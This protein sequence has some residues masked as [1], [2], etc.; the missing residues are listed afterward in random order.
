MKKIVVLS[1]AGISA[2]SGIATFRDSNG[3][4]ENH[5]TE[6]VASPEAWQRDP[7]LVNAFYNERRKA[8]LAANPN[9]AHKL[10]AG[11]EKDYDVQ[12]ITQN[13]DDLH[14][15]G[16]S[17]KVLHLHGSILQM[18]CERDPS[19]TEPI[20]TD[21]TDAHRSPEGHA[22]R[23]AIVWFGEP[24]LAL[25]EAAFLIAK[26]DILVIIGTSMQVWP[27]SGLIN[28]SPEHA[29]IYLI[30]KHLPAVGYYPKLIPIEQPATVGV[31]QL[32]AILQPK[33]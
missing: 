19:Y 15:R 20:R 10:L 25:E 12:I 32:V 9:A 17:S 3:L 7:T 1:G 31:A 33:A 27:A 5:R 29:P 28:Y 18:Q 30:D 4:W 24:V 13:I 2:E 26:A 21:I 22:M 8:V 16:G 6:D 11:L 14:E 23:P